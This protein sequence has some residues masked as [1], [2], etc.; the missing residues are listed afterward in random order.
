MVASHLPEDSRDRR[1]L[2]TGPVVAK[3]WRD[4]V[5]QILAFS[6]EHRE[7]SV[8]VAVPRD[9]LRLMRTRVPM[10]IAFANQRS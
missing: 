4:L 10:S 3:R 5:K 7:N 6:R 9:A 1:S 2:G 8:S